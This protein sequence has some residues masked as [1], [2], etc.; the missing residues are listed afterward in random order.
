MRK[1]TQ[2]PAA[3]NMGSIPEWAKLRSEVTCCYAS[4]GRSPNF[5]D[6]QMPRP[7]WQG[8]PS[9]LSLLTY[10]QDLQSAAPLPLISE[11]HGARLWLLRLTSIFLPAGMMSSRPLNSWPRMSHFPWRDI[12]EREKGGACRRVQRC[13]GGWSSWKCWGGW[14]HRV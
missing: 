13:S 12:L 3:R 8:L 5:A 7:S 6:F 10:G 14:A 2:R 9:E 4:T 1:S 11:S